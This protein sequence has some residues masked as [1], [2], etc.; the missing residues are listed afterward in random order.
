MT[1]HYIHV[2]LTLWVKTFT[3]LTSTKLCQTK[4][5]PFSEFLHFYI[6][7]KKSQYIAISLQRYDRSPLILA[8]WCKMGFSSAVAVKKLILIIQD[9]GWP[10]RLRDPFCITVRYRDFSTFKVA[11]VCR[12]KFLHRESKK[13]DTKLLAITSLTIIRFSNFFH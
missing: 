7:T 8:Y 13:Q 6:S 4:G 1:F 9:G 3:P 5:W 10:M 12:L 2:G 11:A